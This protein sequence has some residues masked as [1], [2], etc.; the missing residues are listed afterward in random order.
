[1]LLWVGFAVAAWAVA[2]LFSL[3]TASDIADTPQPDQTR[4]VAVFSW[5]PTIP[6]AAAAIA[7]MVTFGVTRRGRRATIVASVTLL[8]L[9]A[10]LGL[11]VAP[12]PP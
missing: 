1:M 7:W 10:V 2:S 12:K 3:L 11:V 8:C 6:L 9:S 5:L 4:W